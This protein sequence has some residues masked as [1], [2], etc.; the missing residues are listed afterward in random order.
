MQIIIDRLTK[1]YLKK[2]KKIVKTELKTSY[3][4]IGVQVEVQGEQYTSI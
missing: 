3:I 1:K 4:I 2:T